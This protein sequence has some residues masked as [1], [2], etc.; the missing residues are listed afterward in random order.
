MLQ[1]GFKQPLDFSDS[2]TNWHSCD[3]SAENDI[4]AGTGNAKFRGPNVCGG[5]VAQLLLPGGEQHVK[6]E[7]VP[8]QLPE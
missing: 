2:M 5:S 8:V 1:V 3:S 7:K 6:A 4:P